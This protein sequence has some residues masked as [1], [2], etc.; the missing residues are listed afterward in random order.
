MLSHKL[1]LIVNILP[2]PIFLSAG[3]QDWDS[4][5]QLLVIIFPPPSYP[6]KDLNFQQFQM[7]FICCITVPGIQVLCWLLK[8][9]YLWRQD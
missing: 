6:H 2:K 9:F 4:D 1:W 8:R 7:E 3:T 5:K